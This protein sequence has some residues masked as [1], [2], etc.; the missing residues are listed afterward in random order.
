ML[1]EAQARWL[2]ARL[3]ETRAQ[4]NVLMQQTVFMPMDNTPGPARSVWSDGWDG[5]PASRQRGSGR[6]PQVARS[7]S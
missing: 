3:A 6:S 2:D 7:C 5:Y 4:W 1:G